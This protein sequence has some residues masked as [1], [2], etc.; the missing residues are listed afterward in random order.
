MVFK[1]LSSAI[2]LIEEDGVKVDLCAVKTVPVSSF[3]ETSMM[4]DVCK[5]N[6]QYTSTL[7]VKIAL[8]LVL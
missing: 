5:V 2:A 4:F 8:A 7:F 1:S 3:N 6:P